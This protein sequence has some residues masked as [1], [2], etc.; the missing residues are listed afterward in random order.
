MLNQVRPANSVFPAQKILIYGTQG[1]RNIRRILLMVT[2]FGWVPRAAGG[3]RVMPVYGQDVVTAILETLSGAHSGQTLPV[4][5]PTPLR[6]GDILRIVSDVTRLPQRGPHVPISALARLSRLA[7]SANR[8]GLHAL[9]MLLH[10]RVVEPPGHLGFIY[11]PT[12]FRD[13]ALDLARRIR[14]DSPHPSQHG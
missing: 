3:G 8:P 1:D 9:Q 2:K 11:Q 7:N 6:M 5:G 14:P 10:D 13:G 12:S 4:A